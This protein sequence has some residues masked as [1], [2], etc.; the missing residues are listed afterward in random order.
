MSSLFGGHRMEMVFQSE[1]AECGIAC[2]AMVSGYYGARVELRELRTRLRD[3]VLGVNARGL[4]TVANSVG[5][6]GQVYRLEVKEMPELTLPAILHWDMDHFVVL[7]RLG[8]RS[9]LIYDP[10]VGVRRYTRGELANHFTGVALQL[11][12]G[13]DFKVQEPASSLTLKKLIIPYPGFFRATGQILLTSLLLQLLTLISPLYLQLVV[14]H[15]IVR[16]DMELVLLLVLL[17]LLL[18]AVRCALSHMRGLITLSCT[19][20]IGMQLVGDTFRHLLYL[21][22]K[23]YQRRE[24]GD[25]V[26]RF[27]SL[28]NIKQFI[29]RELVTVFVDGLFSALTLGILF[30]YSQALAMIV[31]T[32]V[33]L[34]LLLRLA[35]LAEEKARRQKLLLASALQQSKFIESLRNVATIK[36]NQL[37]PDRER[38]WG[39]R[40]ADYLNA[41]FSLGSLQLGIASWQGLVLGCE[42]LASIYLGANAVFS[43]ELTLGQFLSFLFLK[44]QFIASTTALLPKLAELRLMH[45]ELERVADIRL[46]AAIAP[47]S[48]SSLLTPTLQ[49]DVRVQGLNLQRAGSREPFFEAINFDLPAGCIT[50]LT[51]SSGSGKTTLIKVLLGLEPDSKGTISVGGHSLGNR[52]LAEYG[53]AISAV[54]HEDS[55]LSGDIAY[56]VNLGVDPG[57]AQK[58]RSAC[59]SACILDL[60]EA[61]PLGFSTRVGQLGSMLSAGQ[62]KR[63]LLARALYRRPVLVLL[64]EALTHLG[65]GIAIEII[66]NIKEQRLTALIVSHDQEVIGQ[67]DQLLNLSRGGLQVNNSHRSRGH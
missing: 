43:N 3:H 41:D 30:L 2:V 36:L 46:E 45:L 57:N 67:A 12:P 52:G 55:L 22:L 13:Q 66:N 48:L 56:N 18:I 29:S 51:G 61:L 54:M 7:G 32:A 49:G 21:P 17:F 31:A 33:A 23:F 19:N 1:M 11:S 42:N 24:V 37:E 25:I 8:R 63:L 9:A 40:Y 64:D 44:Q 62:V 39:N 47:D 53:H 26:S 60:I 38:D 28:E 34:S 5:L 14:D 15:G 35:T 20:R 58:M 27:N 50:V 16:G 4:L 10:A 6:H 59:A 65:T